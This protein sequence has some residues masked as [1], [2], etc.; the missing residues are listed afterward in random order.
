MME[1]CME[2]SRKKERIKELKAQLFQTAL[3][4]EM[5]ERGAESP[6][7]LS[8]NELVGILVKM[9]RQFK[10]LSQTEVAKRSS[11]RLETIGRIESGMGRPQHRTI[12]DLARALKV[13][14]EQLDPDRVFGDWPGYLEASSEALREY[15]KRERA[16]LEAEQKELEKIEGKT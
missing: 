3:L 2:E 13:P 7:D 14:S 8:Y 10:G 5:A 15:V 11:L 9:V 4:L 1:V 16:R 6:H 12:V